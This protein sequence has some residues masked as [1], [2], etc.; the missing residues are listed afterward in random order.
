MAQR[1][2]DMG[3]PIPSMAGGGGNQVPSVVIRPHDKIRADLELVTRRLKDHRDKL[4]ADIGKMTPAEFNAL[5][6]KIS[7]YA[8][9]QQKLLDELFEEMCWHNPQLLGQ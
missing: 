3:A 4:K 5:S 9:E 2:V 1:E 6:N 8:Q 7:R